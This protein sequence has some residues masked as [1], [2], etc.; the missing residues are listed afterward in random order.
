M[1]LDFHRKIGA[2]AAIMGFKG[3]A[4]GAFGAHYLKSIL[5]EQQLLWWEKAVQYQFYHIAPIILLAFLPSKNA[6]TIA[7]IF[8]LGSIFFSGSLYFMALTNIRWLG[9][10]TPIG[11]VLLLIGWGMLTYEILKKNN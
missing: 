11:G 4:F 6:K 10:L 9:A 1:S 3:V 2:A 8:L 5:S 7:I